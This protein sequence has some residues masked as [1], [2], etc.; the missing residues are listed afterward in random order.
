MLNQSGK[1]HPMLCPHVLFP[2]LPHVSEIYLCHADQGGT[3]EPQDWR[4]AK[5]DN[6]QCAPT[7][8]HGMLPCQV[9]D[10][11]LSPC[12]LIWSRSWHSQSKRSHGMA[13]EQ[14]NHILRRHEGLAA[15]LPGTVL[16]TLL[17]LPLPYDFEQLYIPICPHST[18]PLLQF[19]FLGSDCYQVYSKGTLLSLSLCRHD[20]T[21]NNS[22]WIS[23][24]NYISKS[25]EVM[26]ACT[27]IENQ[28]G[29]LLQMIMLYFTAPPSSSKIVGFLLNIIWL[30]SSE[31]SMH[32]H[33]DL[34]K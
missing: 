6:T 33:V 8:L 30:L 14:V 20:W 29:Y 26:C 15:L 2:F 18:W 23:L 11:G 19:Y 13:E 25:K 12:H 4:V 17:I 10:P 27:Q 9:W 28:W 32:L 21:S 31:D 24:F 1:Q 34:T 3:N 7:L 5:L 16:E 22:K